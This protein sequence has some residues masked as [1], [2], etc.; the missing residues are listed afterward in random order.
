MLFFSF[1]K[2]AK[3][4]QLPHFCVSG[5]VNV[6]VN[7]GAKNLFRGSKEHIEKACIVQCQLIQCQITRGFSHLKMV[8]SILSLPYV[9]RFVTDSFGDAFTS[10]K[11]R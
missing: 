4:T 2:C 1:E 9:E 6:C 11:P 3:I 7:K 5:F 8:F 10:N